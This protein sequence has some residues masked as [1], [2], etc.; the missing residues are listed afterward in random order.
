MPEDTEDV[1]DDEDISDDTPEEDSEDIPE[2][3]SEDIPEEDNDDN[4]IL[5]DDGEESGEEPER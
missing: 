2:E 3:D 1:P 5:E 4:N